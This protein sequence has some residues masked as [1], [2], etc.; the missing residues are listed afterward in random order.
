V[1]LIDNVGNTLVDN[2]TF[3]VATQPPS[4]G[5]TIGSPRCDIADDEFCIETTTPITASASNQGCCDQPITLE[6][7]IDGGSWAAVTGDIFI[8][9][10]CVHVL[11]LRAYDCLGHISY[12]TTTFR[13]DDHA[14]L[15]HKTIGDPHVTIIPDVEYDVTTETPITIDVDF[16]C[17]TTLATVKYHNGSGWI[18]ITDSLPFTHYFGEACHHWLN[19][20]ATDCFGRMSYDNETFHVNHAPELSITKTDDPDPIDAGGTLTY[21]LTI[22]NIG[23]ENAT[24][25]QV[26]ETYDGL[27]SF[28]GAVPMPSVGDASREQLGLRGVTSR[29]TSSV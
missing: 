5:K 23:N 1:R 27:V 16:G 8:P 25:V 4:I 9:E 12:N 18:D 26:T 7:R 10:E 28:N 19:I 13:V 29:M 21:T 15:I 2:E 14:P 24:N 22:Q 11:Y 6:Y 20:T 3:Y 17:C